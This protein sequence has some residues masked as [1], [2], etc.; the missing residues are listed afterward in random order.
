MYEWKK[1]LSLNLALFFALLPLQSI[2]LA[3]EDDHP[4]EVPAAVSETAAQ[5]D[6]QPLLQSTGTVPYL[7]SV[8]GTCFYSNVDKSGTNWSYSSADNK[9]ALNGY[10][11]SEITASGDLTIYC[12]GT[13]HITSKSG[14]YSSDAID[15]GNSSISLIIESGTTTVCGS[16]G[17]S[18][19][20]CGIYAGSVFISGYDGTTLN[21]TGGY[22]SV[23]GMPGIRAGNIGLFPSKATITGGCNGSGAAG[24]GIYI[25]SN[26]S[27][28]IGLCTMTVSAGG[29]SAYAIAGGSG[30]TYSCSQ[31]LVETESG[32][33]KSYCPATYT[34]TLEGEGGKNGDGKQTQELSGQYP[35]TYDL[36]DYPFT[37]DSMTQ[38]AWQTTSGDLVSLNQSYQPQKD[39]ILKAKWESKDSN[40]AKFVSNGGTI[41]GVSSTC[42][43]N[44]ETQIPSE[45]MVTNGNLR[46]IGWCDQLRLSTDSNGLLNGKDDWYLPGER[47][48]VSGAKCLY[49]Q[50]FPN[51]GEILRY[52]GGG[53]KTAAGS[54]GLIQY[55]TSSPSDLF[56]YSR[57]P[58]VN[59]LAG[60]VFT[61]SGYAFTGWKT[62]DGTDVPAGT[63][64]TA[65]TDSCIVTDL[66]AQWSRCVA[67][68][69][70][71]QTAKGKLIL[72]FYDANNR[73]LSV[74]TAAAGSTDVLYSLP[75]GT[76]ATKWKLFC[77]DDSNRPLTEAATG[78]VPA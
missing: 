3:E 16:S 39:D 22:S 59:V 40:K 36:I 66:Y 30:A 71:M 44:V 6:G 2:C 28:Y 58:S 8:G 37:N 33:T 24:P 38:V 62:A 42:V 54:G 43:P 11:S 41:T 19:A 29:S 9:L 77:L 7:F 57:L 73:L 63:A 76:T 12:Y 47:T 32:Y 70:N 4:T 52:H 45:Q 75:S 35:K 26:C 61:R 49:A 23:T 1:L 50:W 13:N 72:T 48:A 55:C 25:D 46:L 20:G 18:V 78:P 65:P 14:Q 67:V 10:S 64:R 53:G 60:S 34:L 21:V 27:M 68:P 5:Q 69:D 15:G 51:H 31:H 74:F 56:A 17:T